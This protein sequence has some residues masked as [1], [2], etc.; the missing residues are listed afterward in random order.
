MTH[1]CWAEIDLDALRQNLAWIRHAVGPKVKIITIV[2]GDAYGHG[3]KPIARCLMQSGT[4][5]FGVANLAE[6]DAIR[7]VARGWPIL[8]L[9][10]C[11]P[12][13]VNIAVREDIMPTISSLEEAVQFSRAACEL[14]KTVRIHLKIDTGMARLGIS[15]NEVPKQLPKILALPRL[16]LCGVYTHYAAVESDPKF[17]GE[18]RHRFNQVL[19]FFPATEFAH[20]NNTGGIL[21]EPASTYT[22]V[23]PG[24]L[25]YGVLPDSQRPIAGTWRKHLRSALVWKSRITLIK[26]VSKGTSLSYGRA[27]TASRRMRVAIVA[28]G[29]G[30]GYFRAAS[31]RSSVLIQGKRCPIIGRIT[32]DQML[33]DISNLKS[34]KA[35]DEVVLLGH[36]G[37]DRID[38]NQLAQWAATIPWE[39]LTNVAYRV[40]RI[41][42]GGAAA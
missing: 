17:T 37:K 1:R 19:K 22:A 11:L 23:R 27:F 28:A 39:V 34:A 15:P 4:D 26:T 32:M 2:K 12:E 42:R 25:V 41:Y 7:S 40:P 21:W 5:V 18:Q 29:Y 33:V 8:M 36:Q 35:G 13:E 6:A 3:L 14:K 10:A 38:A 16:K 20:A 31:D 9:G 30:D 24:L